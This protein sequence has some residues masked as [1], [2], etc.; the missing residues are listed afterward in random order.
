MRT[1]RRDLPEKRLNAVKA[2]TSFP[3]A[4]HGFTLFET[5]R[6][7]ESQ[8][9]GGGSSQSSYSDDLD[10]AKTEMLLPAISARVKERDESLASIQGG[11]V[12]AFVPI[13]K[14]TAEG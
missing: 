11:N 12:R 8:K 7:V 6:I 13:T 9:F 10:T 5:G 3:R 14:G 4:G 1:K 2:R